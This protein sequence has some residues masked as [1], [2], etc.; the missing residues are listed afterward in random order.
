MIK[1]LSLAGI[2]LTGLW[3][4]SAGQTW[5]ES[6]EEAKDFYQKGNYT[7]ALSLAESSLKKYQ[8]AGDQ[9]ATRHVAIL[10]LL[11]CICYANEKFEKGLGYIAM[12]LTAREKKDTAY[13][14]T[15]LNRARFQEQLGKNEL[16]LASLL[17]CHQLLTKF[18]KSK[19]SRVLECNLEI[20][21]NYYLSNNFQKAHEWFR[22]S[23]TTAE[24]RK[25][26]TEEIIRASYFYG[27]L[28]FETEK[29]EEAMKIFLT[30]SRWCQDVN[31]TDSFDHS[32]VLNGLA[33]IHYFQHSY[34]RAEENYHTAQL[35]CE[36]SSGSKSS[37]YFEILTDRA[38][39][40]KQMG[41]LSKAEAIVKQIPAHREAK[42]PAVPE[43]DSA[44]MY[45][46]I[47]S[48]EK[49]EILYQQSLSQYGK[50]DRESLM[51]YAEINLCLAMMYVEKEDYTTALTQFAET[52]ELV[53]KLY[54]YYHRKYVAVLN[55]M[56]LVYIKLGS[57]VEAEGS[58]RQSFQIMNRMLAKPEIEYLSALGGMAE[59][60]EGKGNQIKADSIDGVLVKAR[61]GQLK[62]LQ[63][64]PKQTLAGSG[65]INLSK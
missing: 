37:Y 39:N 1:Q 56:G 5:K 25:I 60:E 62:Q 13:A 49:A 40:L 58:F 7:Q 45:Q 14:A 36:N 9:T 28:N 27:L 50:E 59:I 23:L 6:F 24:E 15:L 55:M 29:R 32:L 52:R 21:T 20:A 35:V 57:W 2:L 10:R 53:E 38:V 4:P 33:N 17:E 42:L 51:V 26:F 30:A 31:L 41:S 48:F 63:R 34:Q 44:G 65:W 47:G 19:D 54:G 61:L 22:P 43:L 46:E 8:E 16:A 11:S 18:Y 12:E 64:F 3:I